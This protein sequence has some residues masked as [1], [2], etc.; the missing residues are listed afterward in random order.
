MLEKAYETKLHVLIYLSG[1][2]GRKDGRVGSR[3]DGYWAGWR[4]GGDGVFLLM[5]PDTPRYYKRVMLLGHKIF[6]G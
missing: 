4:R 3:K 2:I 1:G 5:Y 6:L